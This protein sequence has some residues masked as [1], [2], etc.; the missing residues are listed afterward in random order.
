VSQTE[1]PR[2]DRLQAELAEGDIDGA[3]RALLE[4]SPDEEQL[5]REEMGPEAFERARRSAARG[6]RR[7]KLGKVIVLPGIMGSE[8]DS[9]DGSG[10]S[11]RIWINFVRLISGRIG[12]L[13]LTL[14]GE[15]AKPGLHVRTAGVH[16]K[17]YVSILMELDTRWHVRPFAFDWREDIDRSAARLDGEIKAFGAGEPVHLIAHSMGGLVARRF[18]QHHRDTW[19]AMDD[20]SGRARGGRL[21]MMGTPNRGS[22]AIPLVFTGGEKVVRTLAKADLGHSLEEI[23]AIIATFPGLYQMLP[24]PLS[25]LDGNQHTQLFEAAS[26]GELRVHQSLLDHARAFHRDLEEI[27]DPERLVYVA[28]YD[29]PTPFAVRVDAPGRFSYGET[30]DGDGRVPHALGLLQGVATYWV[31]EVHGDLVKNGLVLDA[32]SDLLQRGET[33]VLAAR[34]P[35]SRGLAREPQ[36]GRRTIEPV[37]AEVD[38]ILAKAKARRRSDGSPDLTPEEAVRLENLVFTEY[39]GSGGEEE[40]PPGEQAA[41]PPRRRARRLTV[42]VGV[43]WGDVTK[44]DADVYTVGHYQGVLPQNAE[45]ALDRAVSGIPEGAELDRSRL[46]VT[47]QTRRGA[48]RGALGDVD[49]FPWGDRR[50]AGR[51]VAIAGMGRPGTF[52]ARALRRLVRELVVAVSALP[53]VRTV[54]SVLI[55]SGEG[56]LSVPE[57]V[58]GLLAGIGDAVAEIGED[59]ALAGVAPVNRLIIAERERN[60]AREILAALRT[61]LAASAADPRVELKLEPRLRTSSGGTVSV[62]EGLALVLESAL[63]AAAAPA[64]SPAGR[65]LATLVDG[66]SAPK[67]V[68]ALA[69]EGMT[70]AQADGDERPPSGLPQFRVERRTPEPPSSEIP[71]RVSF[72]DDGRAIRVAAIHQAATVPERLVRIDRKL[73]DELVERMTDP[74]VAEVRDLSDVVL[75]LLVPSDF[76]GMLGSGSP[77]VVEVDRSTARIH[78]EFLS[79]AVSENALPEPLAVQLPVAR[80]LRTTY[81]PAPLPPPRPSRKIHVLVIGDPGDPAEDASLEG[82]RSEALRVVELLSAR[83]DVEVEARIGAP[84]VPREGPL[85]GIRPANRLDVL[86][87]LLRGDFDLVHYAGHG[88]FDE[89]EPD[90]VG[91]LFAGG[92]LTPR[93]LE[94]IQ[95]VPA[96]VVANACLTAR[97]S[98]AIAEARQGGAEDRRSEAGLLPSLADEFFR[99][100]VRNYVGT[101][102]EVND[103]GATLFAE[104]FYATLLPDRKNGAGAS[105]GDAVLEARKALWERSDLYGPLWAAYQHYGDPMSDVGLTAAL[106]QGE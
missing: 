102:W 83:D 47:R 39:L 26:W 99:L 48:L 14:E 2:L 100:G 33:E 54:C 50:N 10:D 30:R 55:G 60:R 36:P 82:A 44:V 38:R 24:S 74:P 78:W 1:T 21:V 104:T 5:L 15:P 77:L 90:R 45:L 76:Q 86:A 105:F 20:P 7:G 52:D 65:A 11:D 53:N 4:L 68:R 8:L 71:A 66:I 49:F 58:R 12:D 19:N 16:R 3:R 89:Q 51:T 73:I 40:A 101:A 64:S 69:R 84:T 6:R 106:R 41:R 34:K 72:W 42:T 22:F 23:L 27:V 103:M 46:V 59:P 79:G 32:I 92:L 31:D 43:V 28:G 57:A 29:R 35:V 70:A 56:T 13:E 18:I 85:R 95:R 62:E 97:T 67:A 17:T 87:L 81:S 91:W 9:V 80:Q 37:P 96:V 94:R 93:E 25:D 88:D 61:A 75:R 63:E 98:Q